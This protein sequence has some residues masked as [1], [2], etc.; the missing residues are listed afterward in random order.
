MDLN[1]QPNDPRQA[2]RLASN[3]IRFGDFDRYAL[4]AVHTRFD[5]VTWMVFDAEQEDELTGKP[6]IVRQCETVS[7]A[8]SGFGL[9][10][11]DFAG[12]EWQGLTMEVKP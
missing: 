5:A 2:G 8:L 10:P 3:Q 7:E 11:G 1:L 12:S 6:K 4:A 9:S